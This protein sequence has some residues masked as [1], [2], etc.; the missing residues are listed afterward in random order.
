MKQNILMLSPI[1]VGLLTLGGVLIGIGW[2]Q[3]V[4]FLQTT[5]R[6]RNSVDMDRYK[7]I[8]RFSMLGS[9]A[10]VVLMLVPLLVLM[11]VP[12]SPMYRLV[13]LVVPVLL[14]IGG[15]QFK[16]KE[17]AM[18]ETGA[19]TP[20]LAMERDRVTRSWVKKMFPDF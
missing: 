10:L 17:T 4:A 8:A 19:D 7:Q 6:L 18:Q 11:I 12:A 20:E 3:A 5:P 1:C 16:E 13:G 2:M 14:G 9:L 15:A